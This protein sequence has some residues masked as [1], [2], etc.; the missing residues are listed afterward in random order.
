ME[1]RLF[2]GG[3][4]I[5]KRW[6]IDYRIWDTDKGQFRAQAVHGHEQVPHQDPAHAS[7]VADLRLTT[8]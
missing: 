4:D 3:G 1:P 7:T 2:D 6:Y 5:T 8:T